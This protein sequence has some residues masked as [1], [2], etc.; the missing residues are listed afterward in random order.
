MTPRVG[1]VYAFTPERGVYAN[2]SRGFVPP[3]AGELYRGVQVP[4]LS[5]ASFANLELGGF[6]RF[7]G[8][9]LALDGALYR[10]A[11]QDEIVTAR[12]ADGSRVDRNAGE[13]LH[14]GAE[15]GVVVQPSAAVSLR[16]G[17]TAARHEYVEFL[18]DEREGRETRYDGNAM[19]RAPTLVAN[20][21]LA[22]TPPQLT[23][24]R[25]AA[26]VQ[27]V[28]PYWMDPQNT[29]RYDGHTV[30]NL[31]AQYAGR[32]LGGA[33]LWATLQNVTDTRY[34]TT[35][36]VSFGRQQYSRRA[37]RAR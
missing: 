33:E 17:G 14:Q 5:S 13:T 32:A 31:R 35:A 26:E 9:R 30:L 10:L 12:L 15:L 1:V 16:L 27:R 2:A 11:G 8:G 3:E 22:V 25:L 21:E 28:G 7:L 6:A 20:A 24:L 34:A 36:A 37:C 23:G 19:E 29:V 4:T 18:V